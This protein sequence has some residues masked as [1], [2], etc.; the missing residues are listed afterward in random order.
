M[1]VTSVKKTGTDR[2][3]VVFEDGTKKY[4]VVKGDVTWYDI[5]GN[6]RNKS[7][8]QKKCEILYKKFKGAK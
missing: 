8:A 7:K 3:K 1:K 4:R 5:I 6:N 2:E